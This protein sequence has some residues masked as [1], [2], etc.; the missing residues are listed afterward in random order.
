MCETVLSE[1]PRRSGSVPC[2]TARATVDEHV[3]AQFTLTEVGTTCILVTGFE[4]DEVSD[5]AGRKLQSQTHSGTALSRFA[6]LVPRLSARAQPEA[7]NPMAL[8]MVGG[9]SRKKRT[10]I[11]SQSDNLPLE[12]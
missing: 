4:D 3:I 2:A 6:R 8:A 10:M 9:A 11:T 12:S 5:W 1:K 7:S